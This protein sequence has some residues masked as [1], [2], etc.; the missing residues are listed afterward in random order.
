MFSLFLSPETSWFFS[1]INPLLLMQTACGFAF[2]I[3]PHG[4]V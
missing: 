4:C 1:V 2:G 3:L